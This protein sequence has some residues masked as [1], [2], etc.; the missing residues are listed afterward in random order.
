MSEHS[1]ANNAA[2]TVCV[3]DFRDLMSFTAHHLLVV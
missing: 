1:R 2:M 3:R